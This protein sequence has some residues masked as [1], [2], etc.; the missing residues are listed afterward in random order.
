[1]KNKKINLVV[2]I[3]F[4]L[5]L[6]AIIWIGS[7]WSAEE[8][9]TVQERYEFLILEKDTEISALYTD[10]NWVYVG[11]DRGIH[12][13]D[14]RSKELM[15]TI[16]NIRMIYTAGII[17]DGAG[18]IWVGHE[19]GLL[20][21]DASLGQES[22]AYPQIPKGRVNTVAEKDGCIYC[23]TYNGAAKLEKKAGKW[24]VTELFTQESGLLCDSV[25]VILPVKSGILFCSYLDTNGGITFLEDSGEIS[26]LN[27]DSGIVHPYITSAVE[28]VDGT[29]WV[30]SGYMRDGGLFYLTKTEAGY[31]VG[32]AFSS[33][34]GIPGE[35]V[36]YLFM[37][38]NTFWI[39]T[40]YDGVMIRRKDEG[41]KW[42]D[43][44]ASDVFYLTQESGLSD[45]E[46]KC[47]VGT[48]DDYW[49]GGKY[50]LTIVPKE[51]MEQDV[52]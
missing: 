40:E 47:I 8:K 33:A 29:V 15:K 10:G 48:D 20:H 34:D 27:V 1:M 3:S 39:T 35:K 46:I 17:G 36:R 30:G 7:R 11:T 14:A 12:I 21:L 41:E 24:E 22:F 37:D 2:D 28:D 51:M 52:I 25:N 45:N 5:I 4:L 42:T 32:D 13:Y 26:C 18:G 50:G 31:R 44:D 6:T 38:D 19:E 43:W 16:E 9:D 49:L 23:G